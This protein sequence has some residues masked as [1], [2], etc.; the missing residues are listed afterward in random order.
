MRDIDLIDIHLEKLE[1]R[2]LAQREAIDDLLDADLKLAEIL[3]ILVNYLRK[4]RSN[5][6]RRHHP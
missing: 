3:R 5:H 2:M 4:E 1:R 6:D